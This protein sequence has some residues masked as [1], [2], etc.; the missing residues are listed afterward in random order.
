MNTEFQNPSFESEGEFHTYTVSPEGNGLRADLYLSRVCD[1]SRSRIQSLMEEGRITS[2]RSGKLTKKTVLLAGDVIEVCIPDPTPISAVAENIPLD[3]VYEDEDLLVINKPEGMVVHPAPGAPNGTLVNALLYY[4]GDHL[5]SIGG[6]LRPGIVHRIDKDTS[7][8]LVVAKNDFTHL[9]L[10]KQLEGHHIRR[11]YHA[12][13]LGG[14]RE[15]RGTVDAPIGRHPVDR[16]KMAVIRDG[17]MMARDAITHYEVLEHLGQFT[18]LKLNLETGRTHQIRVHMASLGHPLVG[19][20]T[21]GGGNT[22]FERSIKASAT[23]Q[24][25]HA[26]RLTFTHPRTGEQMNFECPFPPSFLRLLDALRREY[27]K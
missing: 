12:L 24:A 19:D 6:E 10:S 13:V 16:K 27:A 11:E 21:Y 15:E 14:F 4:L 3:I 23:G 1:L 20:T 2:A 26:R 5:S 7:G 9:A 25:L 22:P 18:Y 17:S 8:L